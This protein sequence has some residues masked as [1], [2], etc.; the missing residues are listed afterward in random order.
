MSAVDERALSRREERALLRR[1]RD[2][3]GPAR[4][5]EVPEHN[6]GA[7]GR[8]A[9]LGEVLMTG[10]LVTLV[11][12]P[13]ITLPVGLAAGIR[14]LRRVVAAED[15]RS[16]LFWRDVRA[17]LPGA[18][19]GLVVLVLS[20]VLLLD[21]DLSRTGMLP[22]GVVVEVVGWAGLAAVSLAL[23]AAAS[24]WT[25]EKGW[26]AALRAVPALVR[27]DVVGAAYLVMAA[28]FVVVVTWA[29]PPLLLPALGCAALAVVAI[30]SRPG[31]QG[32]IGSAQ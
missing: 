12:I 24:S 15:S 8:F 27:A 32:R 28:G 19:F 7:T 1:E 30:P 23:L 20:L 13:V 2:G 29:L 18:A 11:S 21:I 25:P 31:A 14:H 17:A 4:E 3:S 5:G 26:R 22:G 9:F 10:L 6:A 16:R